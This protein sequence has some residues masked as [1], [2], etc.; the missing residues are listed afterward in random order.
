VEKERDDKL[1]A[2]EAANGSMVDTSAENRVLLASMRSMEA[3]MREA[4]VRLFRQS[5]NSRFHLLGVSGVGNGCDESI[6]LLL[7][8]QLRFTLPPG[9]WTVPIL[10]CME[11]L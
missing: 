1:T 8:E 5:M 3:S 11:N 10:L 7:W 9:D 4:Q 2:L 6:D